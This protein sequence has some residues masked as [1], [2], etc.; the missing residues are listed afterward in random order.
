MYD[1]GLK[2]KVKDR[3]VRQNNTGYTD[4]SYKIHVIYDCE[5][6]ISELLQLVQYNKYKKKEYCMTA[7]LFSLVSQ[8]IEISN[9]LE[10]KI[11]Y[12][13]WHS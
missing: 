11:D 3:R 5:V 2:Q 1:L 9:L 12:G 10:L 8:A 13:Y 4:A 6:V 7:L